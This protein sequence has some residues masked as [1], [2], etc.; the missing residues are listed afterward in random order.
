[1]VDLCKNGKVYK[2]SVHKIVA[3][4]YIP[5][6]NKLNEI[7]HIDDNKLNNNSN[8]LQWITH[9]ENIYKSYKTMSQVRNYRECD[10]Y[11]NDIFIKSFKSV[12][13]AAVYASE[14][15]NVSQSMLR[16]HGYNKNI[17]I[18]KKV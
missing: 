14:N 1:M 13:A 17:K 16:K 10:L 6:P 5:N 8:N 3:E 11:K 9:K 12:T 2:K 7:D 18:I 15:Y 4:A